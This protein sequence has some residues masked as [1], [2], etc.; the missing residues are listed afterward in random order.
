LNSSVFGAIINNIPHKNC[1]IVGEIPGLLSKPEEK[2]KIMKRCDGIRRIKSLGITGLLASLIL[3]LGTACPLAMLSDDMKPG[4]G[5]GGGNVDPWLDKDFLVLNYDIRFYVPI[6]ITGNMPVTEVISRS[7]VDVKVEWWM[8]GSGNLLPIPPGPFVDKVVYTAEITFTA[9]TSNGFVFD[10]KMSFSYPSG[11]VNKTERIRNEGGIRIVRVE[12][13]P[14]GATEPVAVEDSRDLTPHVHVPVANA[15]PTK[16]LTTQ[17]YTGKVEWETGG[18]VVPPDYVFEEGKEYK[19]NVTLQAGPNYSFDGV[20]PSGNPG[21]FYHTKSK[22]VNHQ[23]GAGDS[24]YVVIEFEGAKA[25]KYIEDYDILNYI[26]APTAFFSAVTE[27]TREGLD[28]TV[29]WNGDLFPWIGD[30]YPRAQVYVPEVESYDAVIRFIAKDGWLFKQEERFGLLSNPNAGVLYDNGGAGKQERRVEGT[31]YTINP[32]VLFSGSLEKDPDSVIDIVKRL[33][34]MEDYGSPVHLLL[35]EDQDISFQTG[36]LEASLDIDDGRHITINGDG[37]TI[38]LKGDPSGQGL[39]T[40]EGNDTELTLEN[41]TLAGLSNQIPDYPNNDGVVNN[42]PLIRVGGGKLILE[43]NAKLTGNENNDD[44]FSTGMITG[45]SV[46]V[47]GGILIMRDNASI[48]NNLSGNFGGGVFI[49]GG[50]FQMEGGEISGNHALNGGGISLHG[51]ATFEMSGGAV[52]ANKT[53][54]LLTTGGF[55]PLGAGVFIKDDPDISF[56]MT[57]GVIYGHPD[58]GDKAN[59][60]EYFTNSKGAYVAAGHAIG[61]ENTTTLIEDRN[62][63]TPGDAWYYYENNTVTSPPVFTYEYPNWPL[64]NEE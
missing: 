21:E 40:I 3:L 55:N 53:T 51:G 10:P 63:E 52:T 47:D 43:A 56:N 22:S 34:A 58:G 2:E 26:S 14:A 41:V 19:A 42:A 48:T 32:S 62:G 17:W 4:G 59:I 64:V 38:D 8:N 28:F 37:H 36:D 13:Y 12:Y 15:E 1:G 16:T 50:K 11:S 57:G 23:A 7:D 27:G 25:A 24:L 61:V 46:Y 35:K 30:P 18:V 44:S 29:E 60:A 31:L 49:T 33:N 9:N 45:G 54:T 39:I 5:G 20:P 6:P